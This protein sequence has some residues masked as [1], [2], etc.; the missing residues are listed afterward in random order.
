MNAFWV[1][2]RVARVGGIAGLTRLLRRL[3]EGRYAPANEP[4]R[5]RRGDPRDRPVEGLAK[6]IE[7]DHKGRPYGT[8]FFYRN[9]VRR[10]L[11]M[12]SLI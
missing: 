10:V 7:G 2:Y 12:T 5:F 4:G 3:R 8:F 11:A 9:V 1:P 6:L